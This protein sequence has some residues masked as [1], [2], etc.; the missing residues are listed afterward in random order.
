M[1]KLLNLLNNIRL[2]T[3]TKM[4]Q[5]KILL[6]L[7]MFLSLSACTFD[8]EFSESEIK[9]I[10]CQITKSLPENSSVVVLDLYD[11]NT[12]EVAIFSNML[13]EQLIAGMFACNT[14]RLKII[15]RKRSQIALD[16]LKLSQKDLYD[17][18]N[19]RKL[20]KFL[21]AD[22]IVVGSV[23][24][25]KSKINI[26]FKTVNIESGEL[27]GSSIISIPNP[28]YQ[29]SKSNDAQPVLGILGVLVLF[30]LSSLYRDTS[31]YLKGS[32][33]SGH[34]L[35]FKYSLVAIMVYV[36]IVVGVIIWIRS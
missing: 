26:N 12:K 29:I 31:S 19:V 16:E 8:Y 25:N 13:S 2:K 10:A 36:I 30:I 34:I 14:S 9:E 4:N 7:F 20:G 21:G 5:L 18:K 17:Q 3:V 27:Y 6:L 24:I 22:Y 1:F 15:E 35:A 28:E 32:R 23:I 11:E 33:Y